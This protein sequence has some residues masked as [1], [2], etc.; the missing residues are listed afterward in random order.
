MK[1]NLF[2]ILLLIPFLPDAQTKVNGIVT[3]QNSGNKP[4]SGVQIKVLGSSAEITDNAGLFQLV[5]ANK[6]PGDRIVVS[7]ISK[8][9]YEIV[10]KDVVNNWMITN[11]LN[12][13]T[14]IV[15]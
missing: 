2:L 3:E 7:E 14:K 8:K 4:I 6:K 5:F 13:K 15:M 1:R 12:D 9:G 11:N 10:N